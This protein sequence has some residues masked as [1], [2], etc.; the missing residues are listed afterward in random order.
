MATYNFVNASYEC[1]VDL[2]KTNRRT[3]HMILFI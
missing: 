1:N 3:D 2:E